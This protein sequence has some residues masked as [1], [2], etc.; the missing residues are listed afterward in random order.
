[1][2]RRGTTWTTWTV[3]ALVAVVALGSTWGVY[4][5]VRAQESGPRFAASMPAGA[6][7]Y[8]EAKDLS[9]LLKTWLA[10]PMRDRYFKSESY[11]SF[12][13][14]RL[15]VK[16]QERLADLQKGFGV[17]ITDE[18]LA[19]L[20]GG[21]SAIAIYD[22]GKLE[23]LVA[24]EVPSERALASSLFAQ[25]KTFEARKTAKGAAYYS[26][27]VSTDG[28]NL[29]Q[30]IA[31]G[32]A[33]DRLWI[34]TSE[35]LVA[36][37]IDGP[38][39][40][41]I[42]PAIAE[43]VRAAGDFDTHDMT[44]WFDMERTV[45][46]KYFNLYWV[47]RNAKELEGIASGIVDLQFAADG[48]HERRWFVRREPAAAPAGTGSD[49]FARMNVMAPPGAQL[50]EAKVADEGVAP[51][52]ARTMFG[53]ERGGT[54]LDRVSASAPDSPFG[55]EEASDESESSRPASGRYRYLDGRFD[56]DVDDPAAAPALPAVPASDR[57]KAKEPPFAERVTAIVAAAAPLRYATFESIGLPDGQL[58]ATFD[59][60]VAVELGAPEKF[61]GAAFEALVRGEFGR[62]FV[63]GGEAAQVAWIDSDGARALGGSLVAQGGA[64]RLVGR[65]LIVARDAASCAKLAAGA[66]AR[67]DFANVQAPK[68]AL[69]RYAEIRIG[70][71]R[72]PFTRLTRL[73]DSKSMSALE[74]EVSSSEDEGETNKRSVLFFSEN[75]AS[76]LDVARD[77]VTVKIATT[78]DG[79]V[80][81]EQVDYLWSA[82]RADA[83]QPTPPPA[84]EPT[85][86]AEPA[87]EP[88]EGD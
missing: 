10:S 15:Y 50:V 61:D 69:T 14:S 78:V 33:G 7:V 87:P 24:T 12:K 56:Q 23:L 46:N 18:R 39:N 86:P 11:R 5:S 22:P 54:A 82:Q 47:Q 63:V 13:R 27:E 35:A 43:T 34:G 16:L 40:G 4:R 79:V 65:Y 58:F 62:R 32:Y 2:V 26:R 20:T 84:A 25:A 3:A 28:G 75:I 51:A 31:F 38:Q 55:D 60:G 37:A 67:G 52:L 19:E 85:P 6:L 9:G 77:L 59:R 57:E 70:D 81:R 72:G 64:Y 76:L 88:T 45:R 71:A 80:M 17:D 29:V 30:R 73:L 53:P 83:E 1:M 41:G 68:G 66:T 44:V 42:A 74:Q 49:L 36:E 48:V 21:P 8:L